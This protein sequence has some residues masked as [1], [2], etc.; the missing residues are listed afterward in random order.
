ML[1]YRTWRDEVAGGN[2]DLVI[3][4]EQRAVELDAIVVTGTAGA[5]QARSLGNTVGNVRAD[6]LNRLA[7]PA[8]VESLLSGQVAGMN[9]A[10]GG[11][12]VG[13]GANIRIRGASSI[14][15]NSQPLVYVDG[16]RVNGDNA[17]AGGGIGGVGVDNS[18]PRPA[19][20]T[21]TPRT[22]SPSRSSR[23]RRRR[24]S[25]GPR[26]PTGSSTSSPSEATGERPDSSSR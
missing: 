19:S 25:M 2:T 5:Q 6:D 23:A 8:D 22:S 4:M 16:V 7:P 21:S 26:P 12:E 13:G 9:V 11:G 3:R 15:L 1:G 24:P 17:D 18:V 20:T 14:S 10:V